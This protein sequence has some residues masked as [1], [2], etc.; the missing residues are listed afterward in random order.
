MRNSIFFTLS[1][2]FFFFHLQIQNLW[3]HCYKFF[4]CKTWHYQKT[5]EKKFSLVDKKS[6][7]KFQRRGY[8][9]LVSDSYIQ[10]N[11]RIIFHCSSYKIQSYINPGCFCLFWLCLSFCGARV[12]SEAQ[13]VTS[14]RFVSN[15]WLY[16]SFL[17][18]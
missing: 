11:H 16:L 18:V 12:A 4:N 15:C 8:R 3:S 5:G 9:N 1:F 14:F 2:Q 17:Y 6:I 7:V 13:S 10:G